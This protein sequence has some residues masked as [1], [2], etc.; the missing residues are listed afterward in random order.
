MLDCMFKCVLLKV[1]D[2]NVVWDS[3]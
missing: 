3:L 2:I 1:M